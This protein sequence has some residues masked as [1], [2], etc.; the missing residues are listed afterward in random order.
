MLLCWLAIVATH[1]TKRSFRLKNPKKHI[2]RPRS[3]FL[4]ANL[5]SSISL[6]F[7][8][9]HRRDIPNHQGLVISYGIIRRSGQELAHRLPQRNAGH[10]SGSPLLRRGLTPAS[11]SSARYTFKKFAIVFFSTPLLWVIVTYLCYRLVRS[12][13]FESQC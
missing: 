2:R 13:F 8:A 12:F 7:A 3:H 5:A 6:R 10:Q 1:R 4:S 11:F 9:K